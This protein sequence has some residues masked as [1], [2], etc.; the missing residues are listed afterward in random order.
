LSP[1]TIIRRARTDAGLTQAEL[2]KRLGK[3]Q[4]TIAN[5]ERAGSN[6]TVATLGEVLSA[7]GRE[8]QLAAV[9]RRS[10]VDET[11]VA[12]NL[13]LSPAER[14]AAFETAHAEVQKL[15]GLMRTSNEHHA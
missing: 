8:L 11:L 13:R 12:R 4:A 5:L 3:S 14:L 10:S 9:P 1:A 6:P 15:R 2:A 7:V